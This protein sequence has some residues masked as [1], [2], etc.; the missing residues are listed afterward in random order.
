MGEATAKPCGSIGNYLVLVFIT[1]ANLITSFGENV[2]IAKVFGRSVPMDAF[3]VGRSLPDL[4][5]NIIGAAEYGLLIPLAM[6]FL[7]SRGRAGYGAFN[8]LF[9][10]IGMLVF[11]L[12]G[13]VGAA[14]SPWIVGRFLSVHPEQLGLTVLT[15]QVMFFALPLTIFSFAGRGL[16]EIDGNFYAGSL[17]GIIRSLCIIIVLTLVGQRM[18]P[19]ALL[20]ATGGATLLGSLTLLGFFLKRNTFVGH[21]L[22]FAEWGWP[23][24]GMLSAALPIALINSIYLFYPFVDRVMVGLLD[25]GAVTSLFYAFQVLLVPH[26]LIN[27]ALGAVIYPSLA[28]LC[29]EDDRQALRALIV[30]ALRGT[31]LIGIVISAALVLFRE[32]AVAGIF[33]RGMFTSEDTRHTSVLLG[34]YGVG[35]MFLGPISIATRLLMAMRATWQLFTLGLLAFICKAGLNYVMVGFGASGFAMATSLTGAVLLAAEISC[36]LWIRPGFLVWRDFLDLMP[37]AAISAVLVL[38]LSKISALHTATPHPAGMAMM[39]TLVGSA[40]LMVLLSILVSLLRLPE[41]ADLAKGV[42]IIMARCGLR[43]GG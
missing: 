38:G 31:C 3:L 41:T 7:H 24:A 34:W 2:I 27:G 20:W 40:S 39:I 10:G 32:L 1:V 14:L 17:P 22:T 4:L 30:R 9:L 42:R 6:E 23:I 26:T 12:A 35:F 33:Q 43:P 18:G 25:R 11:T 29:A 16:L 21:G 13:G 37:F 5:G 19:V 36:L 8:R 28:R 15:M